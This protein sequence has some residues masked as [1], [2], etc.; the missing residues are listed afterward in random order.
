M[1]SSLI[2]ALPMV[3]QMLADDFGIEVEIGGNQAMAIDRKVVLPSLPAD[4]PDTAPLAFGYLVHETGHIRHTDTSTWEGI[5]PIQHEMAMILEDARIEHRMALEYPGTRLRLEALNRKVLGTDRVV[6]A[7]PAK[8]LSDYLQ[9]QVFAFNL[10]YDWLVPDALMLRDA[11]SRTFSPGLVTSIEGLTADV[12]HLPSSYHVL[13]VANRIQQALL[14]EGEK[15][16]NEER[17]Q[18]QQN[19][20]EANRAAHQDESSINQSSCV[21][22]Q[23]GSPADQHGNRTSIVSQ[24]QSGQAAGGD[25]A[26]VDNNNAFEQ[27]LQATAGDFGEK[28]GDKAAR[29]LSQAA[30]E[31]RSERLSVMPRK[32]IAEAVMPLSRVTDVA[33]ATNALKAR[34]RA[35]LLA[36]T[37]TR[38][39]HTDRGRL[40]PNRAY[41]IKFGQVD[42]FSSKISNSSVETVIE[43]LIDTSSS[44]RRNDRLKVAMDTALAVG[45]ALN[46]LQGVSF[47]VSAFPLGTA[48]GLGVVKDFQ[49]RLIHSMNRFA[50]LGPAGSTPLSQAMMASGIRLLRRKEPRKLLLVTTDGEPDSNDPTRL[51]I[52]TLSSYGIEIVG[53]GIETQAVHG[54]FKDAMTIADV[55]QLPG[56]LFA[57]LQ[58]LLTNPRRAA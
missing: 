41:R 22:E 26:G 56:E 33:R 12:H 32:D 25:S 38:T 29:L 53:I 15:K 7:Q 1:H 2:Q 37:K 18:V 10:G 39:V 13:L 3:A 49:E 27:A 20:G 35:L 24:S 31:C 46:G 57:T 52:R 16:R 48:A 28:H 36:Q 8:L 58:R 55:S 5:S 11:V 4:D 9:T 40:N 21:A 23:Q 45:E 50:S 19:G 47:A 6:A 54:L 44:M 17:N 43:L 14:D 34:L 30:K 51:A 42:V